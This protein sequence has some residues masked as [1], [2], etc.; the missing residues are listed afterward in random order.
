MLVRSFIDLR[1]QYGK[2]V[3][4]SFLEMIK[5][6]LS[7]LRVVSGLHKVIKIFL[8]QVVRVDPCDLTRLN[9]FLGESL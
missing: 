8:I 5:S 4:P 3:F 2:L 7:N 1:K 9:R 6:H